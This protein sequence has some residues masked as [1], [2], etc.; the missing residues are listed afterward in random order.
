MY[1][2]L[3]FNHDLYRVVHNAEEERQSR[4]DFWYSVCPEG[5]QFTAKNQNFIVLRPVLKP[6]EPEAK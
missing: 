4:E 2:L 1:P 6:V 5:K 3:M